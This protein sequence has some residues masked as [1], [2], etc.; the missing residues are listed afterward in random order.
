MSQVRLRPG[1]PE[2]APALQAIMQASS[3]YDGAYRPMIDGYLVTPEQVARDLFGV[4]ER[5]GEILGFYSLVLGEAPELDL[6]FV[7][8]AAQGLGL[9]ARL[10]AHMRAT[11]KSAGAGAVKIVSH[12]PSVGFYERMGARRVGERPPTAK[13]G[14]SQ[15]I[16]MLDIA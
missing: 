14:W 4:A 1:R 10:F 7:S 12:P 3:A 16:L 2:D 13:T 6:M 9:G 11:A 8:D 15:P 5:D